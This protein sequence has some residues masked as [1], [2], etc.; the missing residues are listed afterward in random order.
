MESS[1]AAHL[2][3]FDWSPL[4]IGCVTALLTCRSSL[5]AVTPPTSVRGEYL[6]LILYVCNGLKLK[7]IENLLNWYFMWVIKYNSEFKTLL[8][9]CYGF[10]L[11][12][13]IHLQKHYRS[14]THGIAGLI[15]SERKCFWQILWQKKYQKQAHS[16]SLSRATDPQLLN[17]FH[18][19]FD[20]IS[21]GYC[22]LHL[23][24][25]NI[26]LLKRL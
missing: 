24:P 15:L 2:M 17:W 1:R 7:N 21:L 6:R 22:S 20:N 16:L 4:L 18:D 9:S 23:G 25:R 12:I 3:G 14:C 19:Y 26:R 10:K 8:F 5:I 13:L 11:R